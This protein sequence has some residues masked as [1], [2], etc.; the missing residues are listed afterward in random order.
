MMYIRSAVTTNH[1]V[2][3]FA[4][5][6]GVFDID[7]GPWI[8][9]GAVRRAICGDAIENGDI[10]IFL[11]DS[12]QAEIFDS[13]W[14]KGTDPLGSKTVSDYYMRHPVS[15]VTIEVQVISWARFLTVEALLDDFD[16]TISRFA[17]DGKT[18]VEHA[19]SRCDLAA[20]VIRI[21]NTDP[22]RNSMLRLAKY[23]NYGFTPSAGSMRMAAR[24]DDPTITLT[25]TMTV[26]NDHIY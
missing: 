19:D 5:H 6:Y 25:S 26:A 21:A 18:L 1:A 16:Y 23:C 17:T 14:G 7:K 22:R 24:I 12:S 10:D 20:K 4:N 9:G 15:G 2:F 3:D 11:A 13:L 8:A